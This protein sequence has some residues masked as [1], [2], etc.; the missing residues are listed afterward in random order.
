MIPLPVATKHAS[1]AVIMAIRI[2]SKRAS[3]THVQRVRTTS[4]Q[5]FAVVK[6]DTPLKISWKA[7]EAGDLR[8]R[9]AF[10]HS[11]SL[12]FSDQTEPQRQSAEC[13]DFRNMNARRK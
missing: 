10:S 8:G 12:S 6:S 7:H 11:E 4:F 3:A 5:D 13:D 1:S 9:L 2:G